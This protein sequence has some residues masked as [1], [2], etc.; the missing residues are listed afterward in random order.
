MVVCWK[1]V[2]GAFFE[3]HL[4]M[5]KKRAPDESEKVE[6]CLLL[7]FAV[8]PLFARVEGF[9]DVVVEFD[10]EDLL[11][12]DVETLWGNGTRHLGLWS[13]GR[14]EEDRLLCENML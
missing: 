4:A 12:P 10:V 13:V 14:G 3:W 9:V 5:V 2:A 6:I 11:A 1:V 8:R 7:Y